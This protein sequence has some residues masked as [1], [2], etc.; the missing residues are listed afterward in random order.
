MSTS[1]RTRFTGLALALAVPLLLGITSCSSGNGDDEAAADDNTTEETEAPQSSADA[2]LA[3]AE[4]MRDE[5]VEDFPDP[6][7]SG[8]GTVKLLPGGVDLDDPDVQAAQDK[9]QAILDEGQTTDT[10]DEEQ[11]AEQEEQVLAFA[12]CMR[13]HG[14]DFP[15]PDVSGGAVTPQ[16][17]P[18]VD[19]NSPEFQDALDACQ[20]ELPDG[21]NGVATP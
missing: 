9:C 21:G 4:C 6:E 11:Q 13:E 3:F 15:D 16:L 5:G 7:I 19:P 2:A 14:I 17:G 18:G 8:D 1:T 12:Q 10:L 20:G